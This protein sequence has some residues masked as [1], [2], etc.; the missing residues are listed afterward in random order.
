[1]FR[2]REGGVPRTA[3]GL[4]RLF[5][6]A[7]AATLTTTCVLFDAFATALTVVTRLGFTVFFDFGFGGIL[8][9]IHIL[10]M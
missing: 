5:R 2:G 8:I 10:L 7:G 9:G 4:E 1:V 3:F 6:R